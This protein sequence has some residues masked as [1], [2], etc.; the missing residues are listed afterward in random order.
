MLQAALNGKSHAA[1]SITGHLGSVTFRANPRTWA[2]A[3]APE[4][5]ASLFH[6]RSEATKEQSMVMVYSWLTNNGPGS[7]QTPEVT[8]HM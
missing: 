6:S 2:F 5:T 4:S 7:S 8:L 3:S 1:S